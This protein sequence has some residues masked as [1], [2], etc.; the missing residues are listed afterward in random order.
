M[1]VLPNFE[2][3][4]KIITK[5]YKVRIYPNK[6]Q[7]QQIENTFYHARYIY[8]YFIALNKDRMSLDEYI[9]DYKSE[10]RVLTLLKSEREWL[11]ESDKF[12][13]QNAIK[14][15]DRAFKN[16]FSKRA[17]APKFR[18]RKDEHQSYR[19]NLTNNNISI[20]NRYIKLP[21]LKWIKFSKSQEIKGKILNVTV[22]RK[23]NKYYLSIAV[24]TEINPMSI[25]TQKIGIDMGLK[26]LAVTKTDKGEVQDIKNP[27]WLEK[28]LKNLKKKQKQLSRKQHSKR[29]G[30][31]TPKS[32]RY[33]KQ[34]RTVA[35]IHQRVTNQRK[36]HLH[37][38]SSQ[39]I[40]ENQ[41]IGIEDLA[42]SNLMK[43]HKLSRHIA[44]SGWRMFRAFLEYKAGWHERDLTVHDRFYPSSRLCI[45]G[46]KNKEL[47]LSDRIWICKACSAVHNRDELAASNLIPMEQ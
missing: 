18:S 31:T 9:L 7:I 38:L 40:S 14:D 2:S 23:N 32:K 20:N 11:K 24:E 30:D 12:S 39:I 15:Q 19:T 6:T 43:N 22:A 4:V 16:W 17:K 33:L 21:K 25:L 35:K 26:S 1:S 3:K 37:K 29:K 34:Q 36:D 8:N 41:A 10:S 47:V 44:Q 45:C 27:K 46:V 42:V 28:S 13:L 5:A